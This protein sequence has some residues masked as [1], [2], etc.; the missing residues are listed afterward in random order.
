[1]SNKTKL[2][3][4]TPMH[5]VAENLAENLAEDQHEDMLKMFKQEQAKK[6]ALEAEHLKIQKL[7]AQFQMKL[8]LLNVAKDST[9]CQSK[10]DDL[11]N[12]VLDLSNKI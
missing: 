5:E 10:I 4:I 12:D 9:I 1:M 8:N 6:E 2:P 11:F 3:K 7:N